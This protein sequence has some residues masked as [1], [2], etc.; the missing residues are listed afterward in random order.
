M[1]YESIQG[2]KTKFTYIECV[3]DGELEH[4]FN[5]AMLKKLKKVVELMKKKGV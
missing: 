5:L 1:K 3:D 2:N 4:P